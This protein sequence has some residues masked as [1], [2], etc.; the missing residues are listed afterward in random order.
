MSDQS[1]F[2]QSLR[3]S[4][5][6]DVIWY[7]Q[8]LATMKE[9]IRRL[10]ETYSRIPCDEVIPHILAVRDRAWGIWPY[11]CLG[12]LKFL[13]LSMSQS[14]AYS[15]IL[16]RVTQSNDIILD[17]G[18]CFAQDLR[19]LI[20][21]GAPGENLYGIELRQG[22]VDLGYQVFRDKETFNGRFL[23]VNVLDDV[24]PEGIL[25]EV[26]G[27]VNIVYGANIFHLFDYTNQL[28]LARRVAAMLKPVP[29][30]IIVGRQRGNINAGEFEHRTDEKGT[31]FQHNEDSLIRMWEEVGKSTGTE[32]IVE[33]RLQKTVDFGDISVS[34]ERSLYFEITRK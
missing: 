22:F 15:T 12:K 29:G 31:M 16:S 7:K 1:E 18:C 17:L 2:K 8:D 33:A 32:W 13:E 26:E 9:P 19:K 21:D 25:K 10:F 4:K 20:S 34:D 24:A 14:P 6:K 27:K 3:G 30:S 5:G 23:V 11:P 28:L